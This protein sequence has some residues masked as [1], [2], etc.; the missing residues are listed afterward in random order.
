MA[1][2]A[3]PCHGIPGRN[4]LVTSSSRHRHVVKGTSLVAVRDLLLA[5]L[6]N[7]QRLASSATAS[8]Q[9]PSTVHHCS[10]PR[11]GLVAYRICLPLHAL[12][13]VFVLEERVRNFPRVDQQLG[14]QKLELPPLTLVALRGRVLPRALV[15]R[16]GLPRRIELAER[17]AGP[18][19][20]GALPN[21]VTEATGG[22]PAPG[23][24]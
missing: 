7:L 16:Q 10:C 20:A 22:R 9:P 17:R 23:P 6:A 5:S 2:A 3:R 4:H 21:A 12:Q 15:P 14:P 8:P 19:R 11:R 13:Q 24:D 18:P 1:S